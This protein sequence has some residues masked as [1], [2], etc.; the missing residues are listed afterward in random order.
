MAGTRNDIELKVTANSRGVAAGLK[1][2]MTS[3]DQ[4]QSAAQETEAAL[5]SIGTTPIKVNVNDEAIAKARAEISRLRNQM[6]E[7]LSTDITANTKDAE[8]RIKELQKSI[9]VLDAEA[10][11]VDVVVNTTRLESLRTLV[12]QVGSA[13]TGGGSGGGT[14][15]ASGLGLASRGVSA[16]GVESAAAAGPIGAAGAAMVVAGG[17]AYKLGQSAADAET[18]IA[19][20]DALTKGMG[21]E[22]F[23]SLQDFAA[24]TPFEMDEVVASVKRLV[25]AGVDLKDIPATVSDLGEVAAATGVPLEQIS[26]VF[27]QMVSKGKASYEELQQLAEAGVPVWSMLADK[28]GLTVAQVQ[29]LA[30]DGKLSADAIILLQKSLAETYSGAMNRQAQTFNGQMSTLHDTIHQTG[31]AIGTT[32]LPEMKD[33]V[34]LLNQS[35]APILHATQAWADFNSQMQD[36]SGFTFT[37]IAPLGLALDLLNGG[38]HDTEEAATDTG[39]ALADSFVTGPLEKVMA[40]L[41]DNNDELQN[42]QDLARELEQA[43]QD[44]VDSFQGIG[45]GVRARVDFIIDRDDLE[46]EIR[47]A[48]KGTEDEAPVSLPADLKIGQVSG[49]ADKQQDLVSDLSAFAQQGLE[50]GARQADLAHSLGTTFDGEAFYRDL[51]KQLKPLVIEAGIDPKQVNRFL[52]DV[53]GVPAPWKVTPEVTGVA[54]AQQNIADAFPAQVVPVDVR[55]PPK[56]REALETALGI[57]LGTKD[58]LEAVIAPTVDSAS[59]ASTETL[60]SGLATTQTKTIIIEPQVRDPGGLLSPD[61]I[62]RVVNGPTLH[63]RPQGGGGGSESPAAA[64]APRGSERANRVGVNV[65]L[66]SQLIGENMPG[67]TERVGRRAP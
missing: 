63:R 14:G 31:Q 20:L 11:V 37:D 61:A 48:V 67:R 36:R 10:P 17:A 60:L 55:M 2:M 18:S 43:F 1:P 19:Q 53:L 66:D 42:A 16:L 27:A 6:R 51:R 26:T 12:G 13:L 5:D 9:K 7:D 40:Q 65:Y 59:L 62:D 33:L 24:T 34:S 41:Q 22:T 52:D 56:A 44:A 46:D 15:L 30:T 28:L 58:G 25:A 57:G 38:L 3:L 35:L 54:A 47:K 23:S 50:E 8:R 32:F 64:P 21:A 4:A 49:L 39:D 45:A 29:Q